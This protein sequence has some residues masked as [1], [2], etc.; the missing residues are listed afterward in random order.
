M[1]ERSSHDTPSL[2][3][4]RMN[5]PLTDALNLCWICNAPS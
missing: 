5:D 4:M 2:Q 1:I 3:I